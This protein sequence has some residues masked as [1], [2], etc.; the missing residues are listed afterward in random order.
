MEKVVITTPD[1]DGAVK[2]K[3]HQLR[4]VLDTCAVPNPSIIGKLQKSGIYLDYVGHAEITRIL[5]EID[6]MWSWEPAAFIDGVPAIHFHDGLVPRKGQDPMPVRMASM[7]GTLHLLGASRVAVGSC[8]AHKPDLH[9]ELVSDFLRNASMRYG[10]AL[11][12]WS[13]QEWEDLKQSDST[14]QKPVRAVSKPRT[15]EQPAPAV[16]DTTTPIPQEQMDKFMKACTD[17]GLNPLAVFKHASVDVR[18]VTMADLPAM[19][20]AFNE[21]KKGIKDASTTQD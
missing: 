8:E 3:I 11:S 20:K 5:I 6:P 14:P 9:K 17:A 12:L 18:K 2:Q 13:K 7:W 1:W 16:V 15:E 4:N 21:M 19:R 10:I